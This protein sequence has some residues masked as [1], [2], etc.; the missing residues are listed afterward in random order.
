MLHESTAVNGKM[1]YKSLLKG[2]ICESAALLALGFF[3]LHTASMVIAFE[4]WG[5]G[6]N[7]LKAIPP[8]LHLAVSLLVS[9]QRQLIHVQQ[10]WC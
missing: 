7:T 6:S 5:N 8:A 1:M 9:L 2:C 10:V 4:G 3:L